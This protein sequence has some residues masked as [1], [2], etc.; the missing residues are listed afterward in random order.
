MLQKLRSSPA[1]RRALKA[2]LSLLFVIA[3]AVV[4]VVL[5]RHGGTTEPDSSGPPPPSGPAQPAGSASEITAL[6]AK[7]KVADELPMTG[8]SRDRFPHWDTNKPDHGFGD[9]FAPY[10]RCDTRTVVLL[11]DA[12]GPAK[13]D[14][15]SC[16]FNL[17]KDAGWR[18]QYGVMDKK[19]NALKPYKWTTDSSGLDIDHIVALAEAWRSGASKWDDDTRR[20]IANDALNLVISDPTANRS[21]G[22]QDPSSYLPPGNFRCAYIG[23]YIQ[24]KVKYGLNVDTKE[25]TALRTAV[26]DCITKGGFT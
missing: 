17:G 12:T 18:D 7:L 14:P 3:L 23:H 26:Q 15:A 5:E 4:A 20:N 10:S 16:K 19:T 6:L 8:Y 2:A 24:V 25:Q 9:T 22:D 1:L 13:L 11:R 21:K